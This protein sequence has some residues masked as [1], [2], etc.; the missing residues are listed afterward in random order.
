MYQSLPY[1]EFWWVEDAANLSAIAPDL[2][3]GY[4]LKIDLCI[5]TIYR[6]TNLP[7]CPTRD[8]PPKRE[9]K[10]LAMLYDK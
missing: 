5:Y 4:I 6:Y 2:P 1:T 8:K 9:D 7:F 10:L 3:T